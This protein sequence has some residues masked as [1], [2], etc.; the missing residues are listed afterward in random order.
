[1]GVWAR[2]EE[3]RKPIDYYSLDRRYQ[4]LSAENTRRARKIDTDEAY[5]KAQSREQLIR[6]AFFADCKRYLKEL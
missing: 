2:M 3:G 4:R 6:K 5:K 1:M